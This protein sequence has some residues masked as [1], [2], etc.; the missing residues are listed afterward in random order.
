MKKAYIIIIFV[1]ILLVL[2][3]LCFAGWMAID[4]IIRIIKMIPEL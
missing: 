4:I 1:G 3:L 2:G